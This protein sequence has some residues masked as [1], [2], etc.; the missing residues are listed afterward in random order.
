MVAAI[1]LGAVSLNQLMYCNDT[2]PSWQEVDGIEGPTFKDD[3][4]SELADYLGINMDIGEITVNEKHYPCARVLDEQNI[5]A[6][7]LMNGLS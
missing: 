7:I 1:E 2:M 3:L 6:Y 5:S 4:S